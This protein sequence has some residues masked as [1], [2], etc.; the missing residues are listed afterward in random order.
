MLKA[1]SKLPKDLNWQLTHI[2]GGEL[3][4]SLTGLSAQLGL[5]DRMHWMGPQPRHMVLDKMAQADIFALACRVSKTGD[6]DGLPNVIMEAQAMS[7]PCISTNVSGLPEIIVSGENGVLCPSEDIAALT[8]ALH[9]LITNAEERE[10]IGK[11]AF[12]S[13][14][15]NFSA[16]PGLEFLTDKFNAC[17]ELCT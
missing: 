3:T 4:Q 7:L 11:N 12:D 8:S 6:R 13:V 17:L 1:L 2:G 16:S 9:D 5:E 10:R 15:H 14:H